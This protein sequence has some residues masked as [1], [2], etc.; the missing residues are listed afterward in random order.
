M[1][2]LQK[3]I[4]RIRLKYRRSPTL[5]KC[6][7]LTAIIMSIAALVVLK[8]NLTAVRQDTEEKRQQAIVLEQ[9]N[10]QLK[11]KIAQLGTVKSLRQ[12]ATEELGLVDPDSE[13]FTTN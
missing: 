8:I 1:N 2:R 4:G 10:R 9:E 13:F 6:A 7:V 5:L 12:I 3:L 11:Q